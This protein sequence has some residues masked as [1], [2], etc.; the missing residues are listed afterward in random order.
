VL[1]PLPVTD[2]PPRLRSPLRLPTSLTPSRSK[3]RAIKPPPIPLCLPAHELPPPPYKS[4]REHPRSAP[5]LLT[6]S[7]TSLLARASHLLAHR[8]PPP[9]PSS[10]HHSATFRARC[11]RNRD[12]RASLFLLRPSSSNLGRWRSWRP[13]PDELGLAAMAAG[14]RWTRL[15]RSTALLT[16]ST[17][18]LIF[19]GNILEKPLEIQTLV[20]F[21]PQLQI[22]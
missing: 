14:P 1:L 3:W 17:D 4:H 16:E 9:S 2:V 11:A 13:S 5:P 18:F 20:T 8:L 6:P 12:P 19:L 7:F 15:V 22:L 21:Q 10:H